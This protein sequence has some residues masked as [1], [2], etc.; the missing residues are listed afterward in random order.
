METTFRIACTVGSGCFYHLFRYRNHPE[1]LNYF[2]FTRSLRHGT[3]CSYHTNLY[4]NTLLASNYAG[5]YAELSS[6]LFCFVNTTHSR[7]ALEIIKREHSNLNNSSYFNILECDVNTYGEKDFLQ[8]Y[9]FRRV[10]INA[11]CIFRTHWD[12][13]IQLSEANS[14]MLLSMKSI[15]Y[16]GS[17]ILMPRQRGRLALAPKTA[18]LPM[19]NNGATK[20][21]HEKEN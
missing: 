16:I 3:G 10:L 1:K 5:I 2:N 14:T 8:N 20:L 7:Q 4:G 11:D 17:L 12:N 21:S 15:K 18:M 13:S 9:L 19:A 6:L